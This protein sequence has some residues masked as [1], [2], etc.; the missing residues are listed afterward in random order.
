MLHDLR[1]AA[2]MLRRSPGFTV[3]AVA[4]LALGIGANCAIFSVVRALLLAPLPYADAAHLY[5][6]AST[7]PRQ[8]ASLADFKALKEGSSSF[9]RLAVDRFWSFTLTDR[10]GDAERIYGRALSDDMTA[11]LGVQPQ[12]G[13][14]FQPDDYRPGAPKV[15]LLSNR[16]WLRRYSGDP[17][18]VGRTLQLDGER[19]TIVGVMPAQFQFP[20]SVYGVW[21]P[22]AFSGAELAARRDRG[23]IIYA[24]LRAGVTVAQAQAELDAFAHGIAARFSDTEKD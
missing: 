16:L 24:R 14:A 22:W 7:D 11:L 12:L 19:H 17:R 2:R 10:S 23:G 1:Y 8:A 18:V 5:E 4:A 3:L 9:A 15:V 13:R 20:V 21:T 6:I